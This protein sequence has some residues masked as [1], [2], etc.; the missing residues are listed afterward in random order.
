M[1]A[2]DSFA[3]AMRSL[4]ERDAFLHVKDA[5]LGEAVEKLQSH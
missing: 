5:Q 2:D 1:D 4:E 3:E